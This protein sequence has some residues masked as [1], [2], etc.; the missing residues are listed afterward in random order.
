MEDLTGRAVSHRSLVESLR[1]ECYHNQPVSPRG[2]RKELASILK[3]ERSPTTVVKKTVTFAAEPGVRTPAA[4]SD[5]S[6]G[7][8]SAGLRKKRKSPEG[9]QFESV[10]TKRL[11]SFESQHG[12]SESETKS[13]KSSRANTRKDHGDDKGQKRDQDSRQSGA[14]SSHPSGPGSNPGSHCVSQ[15]GREGK[16]DKTKKDPRL[17][18]TLNW[19]EFKFSTN[20]DDRLKGPENWRE[21]WAAMQHSLAAIGYDGDPRSLSIMDEVEFSLAI[22]RCIHPTPR[23]LIKIQATGSEAIW[24]LEEAY[25]HNHESLHRRAYM[26]LLKL[27]YDG[28]NRL[29]FAM[30]FRRLLREC[31]SFGSTMHNQE[32][33]ALFMLAVED[34]AKDW[35]RAMS[36]FLRR[37]DMKIEAL[38]VDF[39]AGSRVRLPGIRP[40][41]RLATGPY[42][43]RY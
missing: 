22:R 10:L 13:S 1:R 35:F 43:T 36:T 34:N 6:L 14:Q 31:Q 27:R 4:A 25:D 15:S 16:G 40:P 32:Q 3:T 9:E 42:R 8:P 17:K 21:W 41:Q 30:D 29:A 38:V 7:S 24:I 18:P 5:E 12:K 19:K 28:K 2:T 26:D 11:R 39:T 33:L 37:H 20:Q 23:D